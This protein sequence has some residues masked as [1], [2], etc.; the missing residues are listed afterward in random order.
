ME[1]QALKAALEWYVDNGVDEAIGYE[2]VD[3]FAV[4]KAQAD[5]SVADVIRAENNAAEAKGVPIPS[6]QNAPLGA[7][8]ARAEAIKA[9]LDAAT[10]EEL[11]ASI[12]AFEGIGLKKTA[13]NMVFAGGNKNASIM[14]I[15]DAPAADDDRAGKPFVGVDGRFLDVMFKAIDIARG[16][17]EAE[18]SLYLTNV[19]NWR[20]PGGRSP[21][22]GE[23]EA[24]LPFIERHIQLAAPKL[25]V[26]SGGTV[27]KALLGRSEGLSKL[28]KRW[29]D[30]TPQCEE[31]RDGAVTIPAI[32]TFAPSYLLNTPA[33]KRGAWTDLLMIKSRLNAI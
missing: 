2:A 32:V 16:A 18:K 8:D 30:Y 17:E 12:A 27:A 5:K 15:G 1:R 28:R 25:L 24:S 10:L 7:S 21:A 4:A 3:R 22:P 31:L 26:F 13:S 6:S 23:I 14:Y 9:A 19:L 11:E 29:H 20:P 33:Q